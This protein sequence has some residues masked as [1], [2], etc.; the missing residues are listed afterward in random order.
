MVPGI[1]YSEDINVDEVKGL[2]ALMSYKTACVNAPFGGAKG[3]IKI[4]PK[5]FSENELEKITRRYTLELVKRGFIGKNS[6]VAV[7]D[8]APS[9]VWQKNANFSKNEIP[10][11]SDFAIIITAT[12]DNVYCLGP[13]IDV[14][15]PDM[16]TGPLEM[17]WIAD[18]YA[19]TLGEC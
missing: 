16:N 11:K 6:V 15:A 4:N 9:L 18:Q 19:K 10:S 12:N 8:V 14:P 5:N 3:G 13:G 7:A 17:S 1:R 2:A